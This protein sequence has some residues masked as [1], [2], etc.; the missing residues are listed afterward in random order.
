MAKKLSSPQ[1]RKLKSAHGPHGGN[2]EYELLEQD[3]DFQVHDYLKKDKAKPEDQTA[4]KMNKE[5]GYNEGR[6]R[7]R[8]RKN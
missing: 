3:E 4:L 5:A 8:K 2:N 6:Q 7:S 1:R